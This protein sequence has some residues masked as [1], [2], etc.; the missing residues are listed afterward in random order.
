MKRKAKTAELPKLE[1]S[2]NK[3]FM[4]KDP[5]E[6]AF[7]E[8]IEKKILLFPTEGYHLTEDQ[9]QALMTAVKS[10]NETEFVLSEIEGDCFTH[11]S[12]D[13]MYKH[14]H[15]IVDTNTSYDEYQSLTLPLESAI[16][17]RK[18]N[19]GIMISHEEHAILG[20]NNIFIREFK[21]NCHDWSAS[22]E[23]FLVQWQRNQNQYNS[24]IDWIPSFLKQFE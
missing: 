9:Y 11:S 7:T 3:T 16:Y 6:N 2:F 21:E 8:T 24:T 12:D 20:G 22:L 4:S 13:G 17:S 19:W 14:G 10:I 15:W 23:R 1:I 18:G 5:F